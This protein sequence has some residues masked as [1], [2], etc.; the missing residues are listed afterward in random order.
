M[1]TCHYV[2]LPI[3]EL[4]ILLTYN[5]GFCQLVILLSYNLVFCQLVILTTCYFADLSV[6]PLV[7]MSN[8]IIKTDCF[9]DMLAFRQNDGQAKV[10]QP[11]AF[12]CLQ[13]CAFPF[14]F[15]GQTYEQG[16]M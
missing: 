4:V 11:L 3:C 16:P 10:V 7:I 12:S 13:R 2:N 5:L 8:I 9:F 15:N 14:K 6:R 1:L